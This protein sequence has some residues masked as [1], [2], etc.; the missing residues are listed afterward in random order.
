M[1]VSGCLR[2][3]ETDVISLFKEPTVLFTKWIVTAISVSGVFPY[4]PGGLRLEHLIFPLALIIS[5]IVS[6]YRL[7]SVSR[8][9]L[10]ISFLLFFGAIFAVAVSYFSASS[11][12]AAPMLTMSVRLLLPAIVFASMAFCQPND[13]SFS[14]STA[15]AI[16][17]ISVPISLVAIISTFIDL[18]SFLSYYIKNEEDS[19]WTQAFSLGRFTGL[20]NQPLEAGVFYSVALLALIY[21]ISIRWGLPAGRLLILGFILIG[22]SLSL[23]KNFIILGVLTSLVYS[24]SIRVISLRSGLVLFGIMAAAIFSW[25]LLSDDNYANSFI[26]LFLDGGL[27]LA[28][29]AGRLGT[30]DTEVAQLWSYLLTS[31]KWVTGVGLGSYLPLD[32]GYLEYFYQGGVIPVICY[33]LFILSLLIYSIYYWSINESKLLFFLGVFIAV[34]SLGGPAITASRANVSLLTLIAVCVLSI[35]YYK[36]QIKRNVK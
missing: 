11:G 23:S 6:I 35:S 30:A 14:T 3:F 28:L 16:V 25:L 18:S 31:G 17:F 26:Q 24:I 2:H 33:I 9:L 1:I 21:L 19:V 7:N 34:S 10:L 5:I 15:A 20:F 27:L 4:L 22:G 13:S 36:N 29:S 32:N 8:P 12:A